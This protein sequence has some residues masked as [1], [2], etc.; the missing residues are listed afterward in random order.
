MSAQCRLMIN[1]YLKLPQCRLIINIY[2]KLAQ[3]GLMIK[4]G[5]ISIHSK[6]PPLL[7]WQKKYGLYRTSVPI[8]V[9][10]YGIEQHGLVSN[11]E[12]PI[13]WSGIA[14]YSG[15]AC[16]HV[17][18]QFISFYILR[19]L[20]NGI[21]IGFQCQRNWYGNNL[22]MVYYSISLCGIKLWMY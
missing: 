21:Q 4:L 14:E 16:N 18:M 9:H 13:N 17:I 8:C 15:L 19:G 6:A 7:P 3:C 2:L 20:W 1:I 12:Q 5:L 22:I 10:W 11:I